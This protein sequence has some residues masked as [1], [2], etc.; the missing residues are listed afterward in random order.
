MSDLFKKTHIEIV[1]ISNIEIDTIRNLKM[2]Q[3]ID[4]S[5]RYAHHYCTVVTGSGERERRLLVALGPDYVDNGECL[6]MLQI[7]PLAKHF[8]NFGML[9]PNRL[10]DLRYN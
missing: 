9:I 3:Y 10:S 2:Y 7:H 4:I 5:I 6:I 1:D 8:A